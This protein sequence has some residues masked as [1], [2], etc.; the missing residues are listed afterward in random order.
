[1]KLSGFSIVH[2]NTRS[3]SKKVE[4]L[5]LLYSEKDIICCSETWLDSRIPDSLVKIEGMTIFRNDRR[6][7]VMDYNV[8]IIGGGVCIYV[9]QKWVDYTTCLS[10]R[11]FVTKDYEIVSI[12]INKPSVKKMIILCVYKPPKGNLENLIKF[13]T[14]LVD[15]YQKQNYEIWILGDFNVDLLKRD[16]PLTVS[17]N[18]FSKKLG[19][20][21]LINTVTRPNI[22]NGSCIDL[23]LSD[24]VYVD[25]F[26]VLDD[27]VSDHY[28][29]Y[30]CRKKKRERHEVTK[31]KVRDYRAYDETVLGNLLKGKDWNG[32]NLTQNPDLQWEIILGYVQDI[33]AVM[34]PYKIVDSRKK[35]TPWLTP[36]IYRAIREKKTLVKRYKLDKG[37]EILKELRV[38]RNFV[39]ALID[40]AKADFIKLTLHSSKKTPKKFWKIIKTLIDNEDCADVTS[41]TFNYLDRNENVPR[42][43]VPDF[44]NDYFANVANLTRQRNLDVDQEY[45]PC[46]ND[47]NNILDFLPP[48]LEEIYGHMVEID[49][50]TASC[51]EGVNSKV[52]KLILDTIPEKFVNLFAN[53]MFLGVFPE[54]WTCSYVT[55]LPKPGNKTSPSNWRPISQTTLYAK[56]LEKIVHRQVLKYFTDNLII[57]PYQ[58]GFLPEKSTQEAVFNTVRHLY[59][60]INQNKIM[61][62]IFLDI[63]KAF[64]CIDHSILYRKLYDVGAS[65][66]VVDWFKSYLNRTQVL[67]YGDKLSTVMN[68]PSGIAQGTVLGPLIFI[69]YINDCFKLPLN[70][71]I[72]M[73][74]DD[75]VLYLSGNNWKNVYDIMQNDL[76][77][78]VNWSERN[79]LAINAKKSQAMLMGSRNKVSKIAD[80]N[81]FKINNI[82]MDYVKQYNYLGII[83]DTE[84]SLIPLCK[85]VEKIVID[86]IYMIRKLRKY[87]TYH[88]ALQIYK[89]LILPILDYSGFLLTACNNGKKNTLQ[90][91]Q[92][93]VLRFCDNDRLEDKVS[94]DVMHGKAR[95]VSLEQRRYK[96]LLCLM[97]KLSKNPENR[98]VGNRITRQNEKYVFRTDIKIGVKYATSPFYK[99]TNLWNQLEKEIQFSDNIHVFKK[100]LE[101]YNNVFDRHFLI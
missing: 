72:T 41:F 56:I 76:N 49:V 47:V 25:S 69:F 70:S 99:G 85:H 82:R 93:D 14:P 11:S 34:C 42:E 92:N 46:Y 22:K 43:L 40:K 57:S 36:A 68:V 28:T 98:K 16:N 73:F 23:I 45:E 18:S 77:V 44:L 96:Q 48:T 9:S 84:M 63:A 65:K 27:L 61:G 101:V 79:G 86:K 7:D 53:S 90:V 29:V 24:C 58:F 35:V 21:N 32:Y 71:H 2:V 37:P 75:C 50:N 1:M 74:A 88:A 3:I 97:Y 38:K 10:D 54:S 5:K 30:V 8:H 78:F 17:M 80:I 15:K 94:L 62:M 19:L 91:L 60:S 33:L 89:Q 100:H 64:N 6:N 55:L 12:S 26:G 52:C 67:R 59:S 95:L 13:L 83:L 66:R 4:I 31:R 81:P 87:L 39:N 20:K 51:I